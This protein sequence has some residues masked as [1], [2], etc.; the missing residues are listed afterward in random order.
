MLDPKFWWGSFGVDAMAARS[1]L[2]GGASGGDVGGGGSVLLTNKRV[3]CSS[4]LNPVDSFFVSQSSSFQG[5][6]FISSLTL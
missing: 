1:F 6:V 4:S 3:H 5:N 2:Y